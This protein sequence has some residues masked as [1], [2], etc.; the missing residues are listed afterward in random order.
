MT[1]QQLAPQLILDGRTEARAGGGIT[2]RRTA[3]TSRP[4]SAGCDGHTIDGRFLRPGERVS[5]AGRIATSDDV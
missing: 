3:R 2:V 1:Q 4:T 5:S